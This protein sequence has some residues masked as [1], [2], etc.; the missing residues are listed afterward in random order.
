MGTCVEWGFPGLGWTFGQWVNEKCHGCGLGLLTW[1]VL[2]H[3]DQRHW[4][5]LLI[6]I[7]FTQL[8]WVF[9]STHLVVFSGE[10]VYGKVLLVLLLDTGMRQEQEERQTGGWQWAGSGGSLF[11]A[12]NLSRPCKTS[13]AWGL[14]VLVT[15]IQSPVQVQASYQTLN[16]K[17]PSH[18]SPWSFLQW[19][20]WTI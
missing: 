6:P 19:A 16:F 15:F 9:C 11:F 10:K 4:S 18:G 17:S 12:Q 13:R 3:K 1:K 8:T 5:P 20:V 7:T 14:C 2:S